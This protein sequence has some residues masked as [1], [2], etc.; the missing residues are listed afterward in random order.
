M[1]NIHGQR[2]N[3]DILKPRRSGF[4]GSHGHDFLLTG[5]LASQILNIRYGPDGNAYFID[6]YD[7]NACHH[8]NVEGHD[9]SNGR[10]Y[11]VVYGDTKAAPVNLAQK[12]DVELAEL[13]LHENDWYVRH[14]RRVLQERASAGVDDKARRRLVEIAT[15]HGDVTRRLRAMWALHVTGGLPAEMISQLL[16]DKEEYVR[17]WTIQLAL[18]AQKVDFKN[19][20]GHFIALAHHDPSPVVRR[21]IASALQRVPLGS[22]VAVLDRLTEHAEDADDPNLPL[23]YWY[24]LEPVIE[25]SPDV[26]RTVMSPSTK[27]P[28]LKEF[29]MRRLAA[30]GTPKALR[31]A[32][33]AVQ[34][35]GDED[36]V[37][38]LK[39]LRRGLEG[40][41][42][43]A[44]PDNWALVFRQLS[45]SEDP[46]VRN[47]AN[48]LGVAFGDEAATESMR[49]FVESPD[50]DATLKKEALETLL[51]AKD[52][53][54]A[55]TLQSLLSD[56]ALRGA[57]LAGLALYDDPQTP[58]KLL[59]VYSSLAPA[60]KRSALATLASRAPY[61]MALLNAVARKEIPASDMP[62]DLVRQ[63][64]NLK[65]ESVNQLLAEIWGQVRSTAQD[66][67]D[68]IH[69][70][71]TL[72]AQT[73]HHEADLEL[74]RAV[75]AKT[76]QQC[77]TLY[78]VGEKIGPDLTGSNRADIEYLLSNVVDPA[79]LIARE[80]QSTV[81]V[82]ADG[83]VVTGI[84]TAEDDKSVTVRTATETIVIP[85]GEIDDRELS[86]TSMMPDDQL[87]Q[88][89]PREVVSL[90][91]YLRG[92][93]Q[94][95]MLATKDNASLLFNGRDLAGWTGDTQL[96]SVEGG[97]LVGR[98]PG[99]EHNS[100]LLSDL[101]AED[102]RLSFEVKLVDDAGNSGVQFRSES[103]DGFREVRGYQADIGPDWW[104][105]LY[106]ENGRALLWEKSGEEHVK[107]GQWNRY[108]VEAIGSRIRT[109][110]NGKACVDLDDPQGRRR[111]IFALQI[112]AG[113]PMEV[114][115]RNLQLEVP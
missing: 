62:A 109:W 66:K 85:H 35:A 37:A 7:T 39:A 84:V 3:T 96:W 53:G 18:D 111:G 17:G 23:L 90:F 52:A 105:K 19:Y 70:Y 9:R 6:W 57:A 65:D 115:F 20:I 14:A 74:G 95:A 38:A 97:E 80:Y 54:L 32:L 108:E 43:I 16:H 8:N 40:Q 99:L 33:N 46:E 114:R 64:Q 22:R 83:R 79:A 36:Q 88:F 78:G 102:F 31:I 69:R 15:Q 27:V 4:V 93:T 72:V 101:A 113:G 34:Q 28:L 48:A 77:H 30:V 71:R 58:A 47:Q 25:E 10:V 87:K 68:L 63:L 76:C 106:E 21:Y 13:A 11:K 91:A 44:P 60:E 41:R 98:S 89:S 12:S 107:R 104:G 112:H 61:A 86:E 45:R 82:T 92:K 56:P 110:I 5:D 94:V 26:V 81:I 29:A 75:F 103:L 73:S 59:A 67:A 100:F 49:A 24:A 51:D 42:R 1:N 55:R 2:L 50:T